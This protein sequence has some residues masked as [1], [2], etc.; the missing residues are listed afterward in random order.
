MGSLRLYAIAIDEVREIFGAP[1]AT[2]TALRAV[3]AHR[4]PAAP[5]TAPGLL[6]KLGPVFRRAPDAPVLRP[7]VPSGSDVDTLLAGRYVPPHRLSACWALFEAFVESMA[8][9]STSQPVG[10]AELNEF[11]FDLA[12]AAV[13]SRFGLRHVLRA[14]LGISML[15]PPGLAAGFA[16]SDHVT[17]MATAW[18]AAWPLLEPDNQPIANSL[19][20]WFDQYPGWVERA[21]SASRP[22]PDLVA[23]LGI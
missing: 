5:S 21:S 20:A 1:E 15:P 6:A 13:P 12:R 8:W 17:A 9:G 23:F 2:A 16:H 4:F 7:G 3:A 14:D 22:A 18:H 10:E 11:D 19:L